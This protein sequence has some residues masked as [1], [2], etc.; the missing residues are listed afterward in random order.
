MCGS[1]CSE[2]SI[3]EKLP[4]FPFYIPPLLAAVEEEDLSSFGG[5]P[6]TSRDK[7]RTTT[8]PPF[9]TRSARDLQSILEIIYRL[10]VTRILYNYCFLV[11]IPNLYSVFPN[12]S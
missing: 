7:K 2:S 3:I 8:A 10:P 4:D 12:V 1:E 11:M 9:A 6:K 5:G